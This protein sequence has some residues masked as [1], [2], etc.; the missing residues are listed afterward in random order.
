MIN[1]LILLTLFAIF[2][3]FIRF[4]KGPHLT[5]R[6]V[7]FDTM[8]IIAVS[9]LVLLSVRVKSTLYLDVAFVFALIGFIGTIIFARFNVTKDIDV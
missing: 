7:A 2:L 8:G 6:V 4:I 5:D 3:S 9:L 1:L